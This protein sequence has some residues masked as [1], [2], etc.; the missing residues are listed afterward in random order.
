[1]NLK[2]NTNLN[3]KTIYEAMDFYMVR[4]PVA[5]I[6]LFDSLHEEKMNRSFLNNS[7][8]CAT[9]KEAI[10]LASPNLY[11]SFKKESLNSTKKE[12]MLKS[13]IYR[14][15][16][17]MSTRSTPFGLFA[18]VGIGHFSNSSNIQLGRLN[19]YSTRSRPDMEWLLEVIFLIE[20]DLEVIEHTHI[21]TNDMA[22]IIG[23]RVKIPYAVRIGNNKE[24]SVKLINPLKDLLLMTKK[25][26]IFKD[27]VDKL[28]QI[29]PNVSKSVINNFMKELLEK[30]IL[31]TELRPSLE[32][33]NPMEYLIS[34]LECIKKDNKYIDKLKEIQK[35]FYRYDNTPI[36]EGIH[37]LNEI[38]H[39]MKTIT[40]TKNLIQ[41]DTLLDLENNE[42]NEEV[43][44]E[45]ALIA[46]LLWYLSCQDKKADSYLK[47]YHNT[48][49]ENYGTEREIPILELFSDEEGI[50]IPDDYYSVNDNKHLNDHKNIQQ[51]LLDTIM[52]GV[53]KGRK[54]VYLSDKILKRAKKHKYIKDAPNSLE[55]YGELKI[56]SFESL[57]NGEFEIILNTLNGS[58]EAGQTF[59]RFMD[60][61]S[62]DIK[63]RLNY[64][65]QEL[66]K[67]Y[68]P[69]GIL[70]DIN[71]LSNFYRTNNLIIGE[72]YKEH[73]LTLGTIHSNFT[74]NININDVYV[75]A[76]TDRFYFKSKR[77]NK[78]LVFTAGDMLN[79]ENSPPIYKFMRNVSLSL[80]ENWNGLTQNLP[81]NLPYIP[82]IKYNKTIIQPAKWNF[83]IDLIDNSLS[84]YT[85]YEWI[86]FFKK[87]KDKWELPRYV[88]M[89]F[90]DN[91]L[92]LDLE[93]NSS[94]NEIRNQ[95][96]KTPKVQFIENIMMNEKHKNFHVKNLYNKPFFMEFVVPLKKKSNF[97]PLTPL[98]INDV[99]K[100]KKDTDESYIKLPGS[101]Y[102]YVKIYIPYKLQDDFI[103]N[104]LIPFCYKMES[105]QN[106]DSFYFIRYKDEE[107][108]LRVRFKGDQKKILE[109]FVSQFFSFAQENVNKKIIKK[110]TVD[111]YHREVNR[112]G[113]PLLINK[114]EN[115]FNTDTKLVYNLL[116]LQKCTMPME[117]IASITIVGFLHNSSLSIKQQKKFLLQM[118]NKYEYKKD[119]RIFK[120]RLINIADPY[121]NW[122]GLINDD[123]LSGL[124]RYI[125]E[126]TNE[127]N[128]YLNDAFNSENELWNSKQSILFSIIH[129]HCNRLLGIDRNLERKAIA[130]SYHI[131]HA[132]EYWRNMYYARN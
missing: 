66:Q 39:S 95:L 124:H 65:H 102:F 42:L 116:K 130:F 4:A 115:F 55:L 44:K 18:G 126:T 31:L 28:Q 91:R 85:E 12:E 107:H 36:G 93:N 108:H 128:S 69:N 48:F 27:V 111:T 46:D 49:I 61:F 62:T 132:Q 7:S 94:I 54:T 70:V 81:V 80:F 15:I 79:Y 97:T 26:V 131:L 114:A 24:I 58:R 118:I 122:K 82:R 6:N 53:K 41:V 33:S 21:Q 109:N 73:S 59:G 110:I 19:K 101:E 8:Y 117:V 78:E 29:Y 90:L 125:I 127:L 32:E 77:L 83:T 106:I 30:E 99:D 14:Y 5:S 67:E 105:T 71:Y 104:K 72:H 43:G 20:E 89:A 120:E 86:E 34:I 57:D 75:G 37:L 100:T 56:E 22:L 1:M 11:N 92:L 87:W 96:K 119:F 23:D 123:E 47:S 50:G 51:M 38:K 10:Y 2:N 76:T 103:C 13:S 40:H 64:I 84:K 3:P 98:N 52:Q 16:N 129:M 60:M 121:R 17:R 88:S 63:E 25:P 68:L 112:Y 9:F 35:L 45:F 113:G 74:E